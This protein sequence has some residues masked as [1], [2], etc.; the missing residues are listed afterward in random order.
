MGTIT[1]I[2]FTTLKA[3]CRNN[4]YADDDLFITNHIENLLLGHAG[5][6][7]DAFVT[8]Y[9]TDSEML[10]ELG[11]AHYH[12]T[13]GTLLICL[14]R[15][16]INLMKA[17]PNCKIRIAGFSSRFVHKML[18]AERNTWNI[19]DYIKSKP[20][21][22]IEHQEE[23]TRLL[24]YFTLMDFQIQC[25]GHHPRAPIIHHL[26]AAFF[27]EF[28][29]SLYD[30]MH[31]QANLPS[32][33][34]H[35]KQSD[36]IFRHFMEMLVTDNG[37]HRTIEYYAEKLGYSPKYLSKIVKQ[38]SGKKALDMI[39]DYAI[40]CIVAEIVHSN[41]H[42][43]DIASGFEFSNISFFAKFFKKHTGLSPSDYRNNIG[44]E[45]E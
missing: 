10:L 8:L 20:I 29:S 44:V 14:P 33:G 28:I 39:H 40:E 34:G 22:H 1:K 24:Q 13:T 19:I 18:Q 43:K 16:V 32:S 4:S 11:N 30:D 12:L 42:I 35:I 41:K 37:R 23:H 36:F 31:Q 5:V 27:G 15:T 3:Y 7:V 38:A 2:D 25:H 6:K 9:C 21:R 45:N 17:S 26:A